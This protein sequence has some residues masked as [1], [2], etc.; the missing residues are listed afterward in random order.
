MS[1]LYND[2]QRMKFHDMVVKE[3]K[4]HKKQFGITIVLIS[5]TFTNV[6]LWFAVGFEGDE[7]FRLVAVFFAF[8]TIVLLYP[9]FMS[10]VYIA[11]EERYLNGFD[12]KRGGK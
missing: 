2:E 5:G 4:K 11:N 9:L 3:N 7:A 12:I 6:L 1:D 10:M 8:L